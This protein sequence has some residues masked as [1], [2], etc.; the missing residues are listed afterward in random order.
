MSEQKEPLVLVCTRRISEFRQLVESLSSFADLRMTF[1]KDSLNLLAIDPYRTHLSECTFSIDS[2]ELYQCR[3]QL[4][5]VGL[6]TS[7]LLNV[8]QGDRKEQSMSFIIKESIVEIVFR[9]VDSHERHPLKRLTLKRFLLSASAYQ[10]YD[11]L[12]TV[13]SKKLKQFL[14]RCR[15]LGTTKIEIEVSENILCF[16][17]IDGMKSEISMVA[18]NAFDEKH[19]IQNIQV[20]LQN[21]RVFCKMSTLAQNVDIFVKNGQPLYLKCSIPHLGEIRCFIMN[22]K[23]D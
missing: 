11:Q 13:N 22:D 15:C 6:D 17:S 21:M 14:D 3:E 23:D 9:D 2:F 1:K 18:K 20:Q 4:V 8:I 7:S 16:S 12:L 10:S 19:G 5:H